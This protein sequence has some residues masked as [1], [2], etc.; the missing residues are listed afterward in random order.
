MSKINCTSEFCEFYDE[1]CLETIETFEFKGDGNFRDDEIEVRKMN[2]IYAQSWD[3][4]DRHVK[5]GKAVTGS[6][7]YVVDDSN[8]SI[9]ETNWAYKTKAD[10][11]HAA[12]LYMKQTIEWRKK[13][14]KD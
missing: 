7:Y 8:G 10:A 1:N 13:F 6:I 9:D 3:E 12:K 14:K 11:I 2:L 4:N 5:K